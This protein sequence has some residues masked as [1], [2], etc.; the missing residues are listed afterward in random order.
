MNKK[1]FF[2]CCWVWLQMPPI[3]LW[4]NTAKSLSFEKHKILKDSFQ[5]GSIKIEKA[6]RS[7]VEF[8]VTI[9]T[10][11]HNWEILL[12]DSLFPNIIYEVMDVKDIEENKKLSNRKKRKLISKKIKNRRKYY[13]KILADLYFKHSSG[14]P[15][16][17][18]MTKDEIRIYEQYAKRKLD[19]REI[20]AAS[21]KKRLRTQ[22]GLKENFIQGIYE[23]GRYMPEIQK[24]MSRHN[25]PEEISYLPFLESSFNNKAISKVGASGIWQF[26]PSTGKLFLRVDEV[27]DERND[28]LKAAEAAAL[29]IASN[30]KSLQAW[31]LA[32][33]AYNH[34]KS[35]ML[36]AVRS[37]K[38]RSLAAII[39]KYNGNRFQF[40]SKN[41]FSAFVAGL[42]T[43]K[44][45]NFYF[46][47]VG[48][49]EAVNFEEFVMQDYMSLQTLAQFTGIDLEKLKKYNPALTKAV[50]NQ[51]KY[52][53]VGYTLRV[54]LINKHDFLARYKAIPSQ[55]KF[56]QQK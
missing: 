53:P 25:L 45:S 38:T 3:Q 51:K 14:S 10:Q 23:S 49:A 9:F 36:R 44:N 28:P 46:G 24:I 34:G 54:P 16:E 1:I 30:Y 27:V 20:L 11:F 42:H 15:D 8:W 39:E 40:A 32:I 19:H 13:S 7:R 31:S 37:T 2:L 18:T 55:H 17:T 41:F 22:R 21:E 56:S 48:S 52:I 26:M 6:L 29:L 43:A 33:T 4:A 50:Q 47:K 35:G 12:H 5:Y